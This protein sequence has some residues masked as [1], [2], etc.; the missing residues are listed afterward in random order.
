MD[1]KNLETLKKG[2]LVSNAGLVIL[3][4]YF[5]MLFERVDII[6]NNA[7]KTEEAQ[8]NAVHYLHYLVRGQTQTEESLLMLNKLLCGIPLTKPIKNS[9]EIPERHKELMNGLIEAAISYWPAIGET[10]ING[11]RD[12][13]LVRSGMLKELEDRWE[14]TVE[15][16]AYDILLNK[17]PFSFSII[18]LPWMKKPLHVNWPY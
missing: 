10:S 14:L 7:F 1:S 16:R 2:G 6:E 9:L 13:W 5:L 4:S 11:F 15:K 8:L 3:N 17:S 12:N 18:K